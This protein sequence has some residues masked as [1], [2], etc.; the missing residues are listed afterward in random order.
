M[1]QDMSGCVRVSECA[2]RARSFTQS[3]R[4]HEHRHWVPTPSPRNDHR[5]PTPSHY[6]IMCVC[7]CVCVICKKLHSDLFAC[8]QDVSGCVRMCQDVSEHVRM[9]QCVSECV[10]VSEQCVRMSQTPQSIKTNF[11]VR[12]PTV[13]WQCSTDCRFSDMK[14]SRNDNTE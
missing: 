10:D 5:V 8:C 6:V 11:Y 14:L 2:P 13:Y 1:C 4:N 7:V 9:C 12:I 3:H